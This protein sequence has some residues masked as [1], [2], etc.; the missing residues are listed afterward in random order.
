MDLYGFV[1]L[2]TGYQS[3]QND[4]DWFDVLRPTKLP[5]F[6]NEFGDDGHL[7]A[8]VRQ[9]RFGVKTNTPTGAR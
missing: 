4:P 3:K 7:F 1:M 6:E 8:S 9:S 2:D 5:S